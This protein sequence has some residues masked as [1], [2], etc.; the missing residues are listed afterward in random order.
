MVFAGGAFFAWSAFASATTRALTTL[1]TTRRA[2]STLW[3]LTTPA[4]GSAARAVITFF[5]AGWAFPLRFVLCGGVMRTFVGMNCGRVRRCFLALSFLAFAEAQH[6]LQAGLQAAEHG[7]FLR[8]GIGA[9]GGGHKRVWKDK[10]GSIGQ[11]DGQCKPAD[12][13]RADA[14]GLTHQKSTIGHKA[15]GR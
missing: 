15:A 9:A 2:T 10:A 3:A 8:G 13:R 1:T 6:F 11:F 12:K 5:E 7:G 4:R 14:A